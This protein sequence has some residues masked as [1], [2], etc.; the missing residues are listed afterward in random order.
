MSRAQKTRPPAQYNAKRP[1]QPP[2]IEIGS[3]HPVT[4]HCPDFVPVNVIQFTIGAKNLLAA[5]SWERMAATLESSDF[6]WRRLPMSQSG[7]QVHRLRCVIQT[8]I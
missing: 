2:D 5:N 6:G 4:A 3:R 1:C 7:Q 8:A